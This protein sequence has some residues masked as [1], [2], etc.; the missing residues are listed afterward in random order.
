[1]IL[2]ELITEHGQFIGKNMVSVE[3]D[4]GVYLFIWIK[5]APRS[6]INQAYLGAGVAN[7]DRETWRVLS[8]VIS[9]VFSVLIDS[10]PCLPIVK[11]AAPRIP[12]GLP[13]LPKGKLD[14]LDVLREKQETEL[15][16]CAAG[17]SFERLVHYLEK[18]RAPLEWADIAPEALFTL[19]SLMRREADRKSIPCE[20]RGLAAGTLERV[21]KSLLS[22]GSATRF[23]IEAYIQSAG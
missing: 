3:R 2:D 9:N 19:Y 5:H 10:D 7:L 14:L 4:Y 6:K 23:D 12:W 17:L 21:D 11:S 20:F 8:N 22:I 15:D 13:E 18:E 1:M 16:R